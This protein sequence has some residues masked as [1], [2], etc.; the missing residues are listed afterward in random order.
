MTLPKWLS[1]VQSFA[2]LVLIAAGVPPV[3]VTSI[4]ASIEEAEQIPGATG[5]DK[6][7]HVLNITRD[8]IDASNVAQGRQHLDPTKVVAVV[9]KGIDLAV[10]TVDL[11]HDRTTDPNQLN[12]MDAA[13]SREPGI[14]PS[15]TS[16]SSAIVEESASQD[17]APTP[18]SKR[19]KRPSK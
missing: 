2:P 16:A 10:E 4:A 19:P 12:L 11:V 7:A 15:T 9:S 1:L 17:A 13:A 18:P 6:K 3:L 5:A 8:A 14:S